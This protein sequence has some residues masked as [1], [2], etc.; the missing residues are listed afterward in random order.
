MKTPV[1][2]SRTL[3][4]NGE[5][6]STALLF[7]ASCIFGA[8]GWA[9]PVEPAVL[10][11]GIENEPTTLEWNSARS[12]TDRFLASFLM[13]SLLK[14]DARLVPVCDLCKSFHV[15]PDGKTWSFELPSGIAWSDGVP[16]EA[17][18]FVDSIRRLSMVEE[19]RK[20]S[21]ISAPE[22]HQ[23]RI[24]L[25]EPSPLFAHFLTKEAAFPIR[26]ELLSGRDS[27]ERHAQTAVLGPYQLAEW[28]R[29]KR[30][31]LEG[32]PSFEGGRPVYRVV[33]SIGRHAEQVKWFQSGKLDLLSNPTTDDLLKA[34][35]GKL[36][37][38]P[39]WAT[40][41]L[42]FNVR[43]KAL[44]EPGFRK[45]IL[46]ML[47]R[48]KLPGILKNGERKVTGLIPPG[49]SGHR[50]LPLVTVDEQ[51]AEAELKRLG[52]SG[53]PI[54]LEIVF[55]E[56]ET[57]RRVLS[58]LTERLSKLRIV[59]RPQ[60]HKDEAALRRALES[61][62]FDLALGVWPFEIAS[63]LELLRTFRTGVAGNVTGWTSVPYDALLEG[64]LREPKPEELAKTIDK[65]TQ[66]LEAEEVPVIPLGYP[67]QPFLLGNRVKSFAIT[68][69]G[70]PDLVRIEL[71]R[72]SNLG[73]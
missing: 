18:H 31:I 26:K 68:P 5:M 67:T 39:Y 7:V 15:S 52:L 35:A 3:C 16:L 8:S 66:I 6:R 9:V 61:G 46:Y 49:L 27:G 34:P 51:R 11:A 56:G 40:R 20:I 42:S 69:F 72:R 64:A 14:Y 58:W 24:M 22:K 53:K 13:R 59:L 57:E 21:A 37:V 47:D 32:N 23:L 60:A 17:R 1:F 25:S 70:D 38:S 71:Q 12:S 33:F 43:R 55:R 4:E 65:T 62:R 63:P 10:R 50:D 28:I 54:A 36:Q 45:A 44:S 73:K 29:G 19:V 41:I 48:E 30:I 2:F